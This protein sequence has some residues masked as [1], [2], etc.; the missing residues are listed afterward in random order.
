MGR[1]DTVSVPIEWENL[2]AN[3][4]IFLRVQLEEPYLGTN[5]G[6]STFTITN[7]SG[8]GLFDVTVNSDA[9][10][11]PNYNWVTFF[12]PTT[13]TNPMLQRLGLDDTF[14]FQPVP[15]GAPIES[16]VTV[17]VNELA[18]VYNDLGIP[19][20]SDILTWSGGGGTWDANHTILPPPEGVESFYTLNLTTWI[21][22]G[23]FRSSGTVDLSA[24]TGGYL[25]FW[26]WSFETLK[27]QIEGPVGTKGTVNV[28]STGGVWV[29][30]SIPLSSFG[31][32]NLSQINGYFMITSFDG[33]EYLVDDIRY[34]TTP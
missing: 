32:V 1:G 10:S 11:S 13:A 24:Y 14:R 15:G 34:S 29:E 23:I 17:T 30:K 28:P 12:Y 25:K 3:V 7:T 4:P 9:P 31:S 18:E 33:A 2:G 16:E 27:V 22:W 26:L 19:V 21:G 6:G 20:G 5:V 8:S